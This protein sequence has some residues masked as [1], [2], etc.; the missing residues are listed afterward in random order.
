MA[1][2]K[3][4]TKS[5]RTTN[6]KISREKSAGYLGSSDF[7]LVSRLFGRKWTNSTYLEQYGK[8][9]YVYA[10]VSKIAEKYGSVD[11]LLKRIINSKG[12]VENIYNH[13][14]LDLLYRVNPFYTKAEY[15]E[16]DCIN[17]KLSGDSFTLKVRNDY[18]KVVELWPIRPDKVTIHSDPEKYISHYSVVNETGQSYDI[19]VED[20][21]HIKYPSPIDTFLGMSPLSSAKN[22]V[23]TED[24]A[25]EYQKNFFINNARPD[26]V[27][28]SDQILSPQQ[29]EDLMKAW[30]KK[31]K[32][33]G[34]NSKIGFL[35]GGLKYN[36]ISLS[37]KEMDFIESMKFTRD[38]ILVAFKTP[39]PIVAITDD[40]N[41]ANAETAMEIFYSENIVP[42]IKRFIDKINEELIIP[43]FGEE[44]YLDY[45]DPTPISREMRLNE[46]NLGCDRWITPNEIR[47][48][49]GRVP[50]EGGDKLLRAVSFQPINDA[51]YVSEVKSYHKNLHGRRALRLKMEMKEQFNS[52]IK[53]VVSDIKKKKNEKKGTSIFKTESSRNKYYD[54]RMK[55]IDNKSAKIET[56]M[57]SLAKKQEKGFS[58]KI[59]GL[60]DKKQIEKLFDTKEQIDKFKKSI[61]PLISSIFVESE[62]DAMS[63]IGEKNFKAP[64]RKEIDKAVLVL[65]QT[66]AEFFATSV[67]NTTLE[68]LTVSLSEGIVAGESI[69]VLKNR[70]K[71]VYSEFKNYRAKLI[72]RTETNAVVNEAHLNAYKES[73][74]IKGKEWIAT[75]D[76]KT[77]DEHLVM[78]G[79]IV[80]NGKQ[81]SNGE[82]FPS[83]PNC[84]CTIAPVVRV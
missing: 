25:S 34:K 51:G 41:R 83:S 70:V 46:Y 2:K 60:K 17:R 59:E 8:S 1:I 73:D 26:A 31:H 43:D 61:F 35:W 84:R 66:R 64:L 55:D 47:E 75:K 20:M 74:N 32:G 82:M 40:V 62:Q 67:N 11:F 22:R 42:E 44:Y 76:G 78:D 54:F 50:M 5:I 63:I 56:L 38:D 58:K 16:T 80:A 57:L 39:K 7:N 45:I 12:D 28:E 23:D 24:Y 18:G 19:P 15:M 36:Q 72:A 14:I 37:Q 71:E 4:K 53:S 21:I 77:R 52:Y 79:E 10:C 69:E 3:T 81:F 13:E 33:E 6:K 49:T 30:E 9:L 65:L 48:E 68:T 29:R 27:L